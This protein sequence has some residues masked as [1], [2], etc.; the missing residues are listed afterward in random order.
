MKIIQQILIAKQIVYYDGNLS[1]KICKS[2]LVD[3]LNSQFPSVV[4]K[5][6]WRIKCRSLKMKHYTILL[7]INLSVFSSIKTCFI[8]LIN[9]DHVY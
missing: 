1:V 9:A 5:W 3:F 6:M 4:T 2:C 7:V 8:V